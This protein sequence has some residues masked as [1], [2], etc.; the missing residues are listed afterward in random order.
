MLQ[1]LHGSNNKNMT[2]EEEIL[3]NKYG[4]G[5]I[6]PLILID[7]FNEKDLPSKRN[8]LEDIIYYFILQSKAVE[9]DISTAIEM[10]GLKH[11]YTPCIMIRKG[12]DSHNLELIAKLP[13]NEISKVFILFISIFKVAYQRKFL[14]EKNN[15]NKWWY[16]DLSNEENLDQIR[17]MLNDLK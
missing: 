1:Y 12:L 5:L 3:L 2:F 17:K 15:P 9:S 6:S 13:N 4:Q 10:S 7:E 14:T 8:Y 16:W 11:T